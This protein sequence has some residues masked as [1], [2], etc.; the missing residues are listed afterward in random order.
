[1]DAGSMGLGPSWHGA[2]RFVGTLVCC[3]TPSCY[4][5]CLS[6]ERQMYIYG[7]PLCW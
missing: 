3:H 7:S 2:G 4:P 6:L 5:S 1:M